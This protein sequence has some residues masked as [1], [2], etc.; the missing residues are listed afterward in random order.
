MKSPA[1]D[2]STCLHFTGILGSLIVSHLDQSCFSGRSSPGSPAGSGRTTPATWSSTPRRGACSV[3]RYH[4]TPAPDSPAR[5]QAAE[6]KM[7]GYITIAHGVACSTAAEREV[8]S[9]CLCTVVI[10]FCTSP[11]CVGVASDNPH[12]HSPPATRVRACVRTCLCEVAPTCA[13]YPAS[14]VLVRLA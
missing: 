14:L 11:F 1:D 10:T 6:V 2:L 7:V 13:M 9:L 8:A 3:P 5:R 4:P 12:H